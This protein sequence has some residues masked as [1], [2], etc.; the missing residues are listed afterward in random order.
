MLALKTWVLLC[1]QRLALNLWL[2]C[3]SICWGCSYRQASPCLTGGHSEMKWVRDF[4]FYLVLAKTVLFSVRFWE[5]QPGRVKGFCWRCVK[6]RVEG[7][8]RAIWA[9]F[10]HY[11]R[12]LDFPRNCSL[13]AMDKKSKINILF[14]IPLYKVWVWMKFQQVV[15]PLILQ[16]SEFLTFSFYSV[17]LKI[18]GNL[19]GWDQSCEPICFTWVWHSSVQSLGNSARWSG[20]PS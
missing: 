9:C 1:S 16:H 6:S 13:W 17:V 11:L 5:P 3:S 15:I 12:V 18:P 4:L 2:S 7:A 20:K 19:A 10:P 8:G 14:G